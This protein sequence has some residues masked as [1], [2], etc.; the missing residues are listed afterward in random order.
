MSSYIIRFWHDQTSN[1]S[2]ALNSESPSQIYTSIDSI[3][4]SLS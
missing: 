4:L 1:K 3:H 2:H